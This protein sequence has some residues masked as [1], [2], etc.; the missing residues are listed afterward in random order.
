M[1]AL[2]FLK[3]WLNF[4]EDSSLDEEE[5]VKFYY[6]LLRRPELDEMFIEYTKTTDS[7]RMTP[8]DLMKFMS[9]V[10][11]IYISK[12][13]SIQIINGFEPTNDKSTLSN[14]GFIH[15]MMFSDLHNITNNYAANIVDQDMSQPLSHYWIASSHNT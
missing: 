6:G 11:K 15:F 9:N 1:S 2:L 12:E 8:E 4:L 14:E 10:Q 7:S 3:I 5:F 13:E